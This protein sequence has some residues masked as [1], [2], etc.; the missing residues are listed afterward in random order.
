M[1]FA[2]WIVGNHELCTLLKERVNRDLLPKET[3]F[4]KPHQFI[5][6]LQGLN[7][8]QPLAGRVVVICPMTLKSS[9]IFLSR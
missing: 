9:M 5:L 6:K 2:Q 3:G 7:Y 8:H 4:F 1:T